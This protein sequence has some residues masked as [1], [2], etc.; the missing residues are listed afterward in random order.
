M[1]MYIYTYSG[2]PCFLW[3][4]QS[5]RVTSMYCTRVCKTGVV[6]NETLEREGGLKYEGTTKTTQRRLTYYAL[7]RNHP[8]RKPVSITPIFTFQNV[9][10]GVQIWWT[11][12]TLPRLNNVSTCV[13]VSF[14]WWLATSTNTH[15]HTGTCSWPKSSKHLIPAR[16]K[17]NFFPRCSPCPNLWP[18][19]GSCF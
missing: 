12:H 4:T 3:Y 10:L 5:N 6:A 1:Y 16:L 19:S 17:W 13:T 9:L 18:P 2:W 15:K 14:F 11:P 8:K 7:P